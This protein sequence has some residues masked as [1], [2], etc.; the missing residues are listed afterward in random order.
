VSLFSLAHYC[1]ENILRFQG[2][3]RFSAMADV[4]DFAALA[5]ARTLRSGLAAAYATLGKSRSS[6]RILPIAVQLFVGHPLTIAAASRIFSNSR[7]AAR[8]HLV[9]LEAEGLAEAMGRRKR[10]SVSLG[11]DLR[12]SAKPAPPLPLN[13]FP[14]CSLGR[15]AFV[16]EGTG[17]AGR[18]N[19]RRG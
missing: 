18:R 17:S 11:I 15:Q 14:A 19:R 9:R 6:S 3:K 8:K 16:A 12:R 10:V 5:D 1:L 7:L 2:V 13:D 4:A